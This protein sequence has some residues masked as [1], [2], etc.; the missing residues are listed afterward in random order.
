MQSRVHEGKVVWVKY[1]QSVVGK[2][3]GN[4][5]GS[6]CVWNEREKE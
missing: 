5:K 4:G 6:Y 3:C 2:I 1:Q